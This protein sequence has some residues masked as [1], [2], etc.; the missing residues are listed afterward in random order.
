MVTRSLTIERAKYGLLSPEARFFVGQAEL[1]HFR[2]VTTHYTLCFELPA[3][4]V[5]HSTIHLT[6]PVS[7]GVVRFT[8]LHK[9]SSQQATSSL[10]SAV[11]VL[12]VVGQLRPA[13]ELGTVKRSAQA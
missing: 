1:G 13:R 11:Q 3:A 2:K 5:Y 7:L 10:D 6:K 9:V 12:M 4:V 8:I